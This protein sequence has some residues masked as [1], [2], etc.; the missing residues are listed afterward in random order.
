GYG[1]AVPRAAAGRVLAVVVMVCAIAFLTVV[2]AAITAALIEHERRRLPTVESRIELQLQ[3]ISSRLARLEDGLR[4][5]DLPDRGLADG[6][7]RDAPQA[8][9]RH[10][11][12]GEHR[13]NRLTSTSC[14]AP[15]RLTQNTAQRP[16]EAARATVSPS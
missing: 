8:R 1:D 5:R 7:G 13:A 12:L 9:A 15:W 11:Q 2:T 14:A 10:R 4:M 6:Q 3:E 16:H